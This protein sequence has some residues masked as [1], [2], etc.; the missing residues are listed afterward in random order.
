MSFFPL[1]SRLF[2]FLRSE[3]VLEFSFSI[4][5]H[6]FFVLLFGFYAL[7]VLRAG[8]SWCWGS[9]AFFISFILFH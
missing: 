8:S 4:T 2:F 1:Y 7:G 6:L 5:S 9:K 3:G